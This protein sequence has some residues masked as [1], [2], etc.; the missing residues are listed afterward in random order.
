MQQAVTLWQG[1]D[2]AE[3]VANSQF[4]LASAYFAKADY[5]NALKSFEEALLTAQKLEDVRLQGKIIIRIGDSQL[6]LKVN[7]KAIAAY[8]QA[9]SFFH[10]QGDSKGEADAILSIA[11]IYV[12]MGKVDEAL[13]V[14]TDALALAQANNDLAAQGKI[15][16][17][18]GRLHEALKRP[19]AALAAYNQVCGHLEKATSGCS[20]GEFAGQCW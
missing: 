2:Q 6:K 9:Q 4:N 17:S 16:D 3:G 19:D 18:Q 13:K 20:A 15:Y 12:G 10:E 1:T 8:Q 5:V 11:G 7:D 14:Y